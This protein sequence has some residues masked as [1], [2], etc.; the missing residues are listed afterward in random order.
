MG[1]A[2]R[3]SKS[4][5]ATLSKRCTRIGEKAAELITSECIKH[6]V[7]P[8]DA[9]K[10]MLKYLG[11]SSTFP[12][13]RKFVSRLPLQARQ[14]VWEFWHTECQESTMT[15]ALARLRVSKKPGCEEDLEY[16]PPVCIVIKRKKEFY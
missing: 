6:D 10:L 1:E 4:E 11:L 7:D 2:Q 13:V 12:M 8:E 9:V 16:A 15:T 3:F 5:R 14:I